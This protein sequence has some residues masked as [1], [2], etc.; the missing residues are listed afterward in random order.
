MS[1][2][3]T[4]Q[5]LDAADWDKEEVPAN[6]QRA[7]TYLNALLDIDSVSMTNALGHEVR[8]RGNAAK[9]FERSN[10]LIGVDKRDR[11]Y[12]SAFG[13]LNGLL[14]TPSFRLGV[15]VD[16]EFNTYEGF[17]IYRTAS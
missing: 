1:D 8:L 14:M 4:W 6:L 5:I 15:E 12:L 9:A 10:A 3:S 16:E 13:I 2:N 11:P 17:F 7:C